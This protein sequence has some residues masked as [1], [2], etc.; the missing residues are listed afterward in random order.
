MNRSSACTATYIEAGAETKEELFS[1]VKDG[2]YIDDISHGSGMTTFTIAPFRSYR[3]R[4]GKVAEPVRISVI[5]GNVMSTLNDIDGLSD[6]VEILSLGTGGCGKGEQYP[7]PV[8]FG[9][10]YVRVNNIHVQ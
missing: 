7:L 9:G 8:G 1:K 6:E 2:I 10:P 4:D 5:T 3:I